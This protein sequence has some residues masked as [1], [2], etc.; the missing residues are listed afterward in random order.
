VNDLN[1]DNETNPSP[2]KKSFQRLKDR[3]KPML[4]GIIRNQFLSPLNH[5]LYDE[6]TAILKEEI[7][8]AALIPPA[9][10]NFYN[11]Y[12]IQWYLAKT[13]EEFNLKPIQ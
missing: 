2:F 12:I 5:I 8:P 9:Q 11:S 10:P 3:V 1:L 7:D 6:I 13:A 4:P